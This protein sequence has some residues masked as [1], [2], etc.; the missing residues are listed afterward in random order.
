MTSAA[1]RFSL[2]LLAGLAVLPAAVACGL[3]GGG[4][5]GFAV[6]L[7]ALLAGAGS[8]VWRSPAAIGGAVCGLAAGVLALAWVLSWFAGTHGL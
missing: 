3:F 7:L 2:G 1:G 4:L 6:A 5:A 8:L